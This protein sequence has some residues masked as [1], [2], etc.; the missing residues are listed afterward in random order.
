M[1]SD[2]SPSHFAAFFC[3]SR[4]RRQDG[5]LRCLTFQPLQARRR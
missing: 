2:L 4:S 1:I 5:G 3:W